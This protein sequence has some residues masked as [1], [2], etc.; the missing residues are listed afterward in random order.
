M[1]FEDMDN[2]EEMDNMDEVDNFDDMDFDFDD[3]P[4]PEESNNR[5]FIIVASILGAIAVIALICIIVYASVI[6][7]L[8]QN[9][10]A[11]QVALLN[12][13]NTEVA[14]QITQTL[15]AK[16]F[17]N[18]P[19]ITNTPLPP[20]ATL[21][22]TPVVAVPTNTSVVAEVGARTATVSAL[23]TEAAVAQKTLVPTST[24]L[25]ST[26]FA[27]DV[28]LPGL[29][30]FAVLLITVIFLARRLRTA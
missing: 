16:S 30:G 14:F 23:L 2:M 3:A 27:D 9:N 13:Q 28:G 18:T 12:A 19:T 5:T 10:D 15:L 11:T 8:N 26:G 22:P 25:P 17:T 7:P 4:P 24:A 20:T 1:A 21:T 29:L 6:R